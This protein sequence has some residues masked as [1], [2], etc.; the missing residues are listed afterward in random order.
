MMLGNPGPPP[1]PA[2]GRNA[3]LKPQQPENLP[4]ADIHLEREHALGLPAARKI[5]FT[6]AE[7]A[8]AKFGLECTYA[9]GQASDLVSFSRSGVQGT[10]AVTENNFEIN[11]TL[12]FLA[13]VF[14]D[15]IEAEMVKNLDALITARPAAA[16]QKIA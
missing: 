3:A 9:Q 5:A 16:P 15:K 14:K 2:Q 1:Q 12:G 7:Q 8:E 10:L 4:M 13:G 6:W 11:V